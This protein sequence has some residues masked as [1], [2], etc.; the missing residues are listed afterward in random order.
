M[1]PGHR[2]NELAPNSGGVS[3]EPC[4]SSAE[5]LSGKNLSIYQPRQNVASG[6]TER[7]A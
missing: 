3:L 2:F 4:K 6:S 7:A 1:V 5:N